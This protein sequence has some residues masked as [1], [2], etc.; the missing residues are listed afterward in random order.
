MPIVVPTVSINTATAEI[1][2]AFKIDNSCAM[3]ISDHIFWV[4]GAVLTC[5]VSTGLAFHGP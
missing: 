3:V 4:V 2:R 5:T 1:Q